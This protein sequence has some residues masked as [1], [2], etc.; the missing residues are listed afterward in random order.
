M[1]VRD[2][3]SVGVWEGWVVDGDEHLGVMEVWENGDGSVEVWKCGGREVG[4]GSI[5]VWERWVVM[6]I[7]G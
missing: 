1:S 2:Y 3:G 4:D 7:M 6:S 5:G